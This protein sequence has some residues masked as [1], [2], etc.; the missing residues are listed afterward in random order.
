MAQAFLRRFAQEQRRGSLSFSDDAI[1]ALERHRW[2]GNVR[3][4]LNVIRRAVIMA[5]GGRVTAADLNLPVPS[6]AGAAAAGM[7]VDLRRVREAAERQAILAAMA[8]TDGNVARAAEMLGVSRPTLY[9]LMNRL[10]IR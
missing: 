9:D 6:D 1:A 7:D 8:R 2:P 4:L 5:D 10:S 3:E